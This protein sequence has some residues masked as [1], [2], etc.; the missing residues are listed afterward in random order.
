FQSRSS[1]IRYIALLYLGSLAFSF[2]AIKPAYAAPL[3]QSYLGCRMPS[4]S[5]LCNCQSATFF[6]ICKVESA[7]EL[8]CAEDFSRVI[9]NRKTINKDGNKYFFISSI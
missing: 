7:R 3:V 6:I 9:V 8:F 5:Q 2:K 4:R 1:P